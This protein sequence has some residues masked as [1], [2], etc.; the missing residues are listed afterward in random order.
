MHLKTGKT[1]S[2]ANTFVISKFYYAS[3]FTGK[4]LILKVQKIHHGTLQVMQVV[5]ETYDKVYE[6]LLLE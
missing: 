6:D 2:L 4:T 3:M 1:P 5:F